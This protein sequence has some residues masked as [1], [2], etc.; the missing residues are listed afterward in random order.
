[1]SFKAIFSLF[2]TYVLGLQTN[3]YGRKELLN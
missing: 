1:M 2:F 3:K